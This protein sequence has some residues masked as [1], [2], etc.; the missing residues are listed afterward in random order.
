MRD[1][2]RE[3]RMPAPQWPA[4]E[5]PHPMPSLLLNSAESP[6]RRVAV[7]CVFR[8]PCFL[9]LVAILYATLPFW[10]P[11]DWIRHNASLSNCCAPNR[12]VSIGRISLS[13]G[14]G[15]QL[16]DVVVRGSGPESSGRPLWL[17][18][19]P[20]VLRLNFFC[21]YRLTARPERLSLN[22]VDVFLGCC[23]RRTAAESS[24]PRSWHGPEPRFAMMTSAMSAA[25]CFRSRAITPHVWTESNVDSI[26]TRGSCD[27][28][29]R[30]A[31]WPGGG[32]GPYRPGACS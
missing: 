7:W 17:A 13:W 28:R 2:P 20:S 25:T 11:P 24:R 18:L 1:G 4:I 10:L 29:R 27:C 3:R 16:N 19:A 26:Q 14:R 9:A 5:N 15:I 22:G 21:D 23:S 32:G 31:R 30:P 6:L 12:P 8:N